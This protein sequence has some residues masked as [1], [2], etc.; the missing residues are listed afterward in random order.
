MTQIHAHASTH[1][2]AHIDT[3]TRLICHKKQRGPKTAVISGTR[4][5]RL[6]FSTPRSLTGSNSISPRCSSVLPRTL[7]TTS[8]WTHI[9]RE[10]GNDLYLSSHIHRFSILMKYLTS[11]PFFDTVVRW[12]WIS[13]LESPRKWIRP[14]GERGLSSVP[15]GFSTQLMVTRWKDVWLCN[16][17]NLSWTTS[18][19]AYANYWKKT[20]IQS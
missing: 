3:H 1:A 18:N 17:R 12:D 10:R 6:V 14:L 7:T 11:Q 9:T 20:V 19:P 2:C 13:L 5:D 8:T 16:R 15:D 4:W